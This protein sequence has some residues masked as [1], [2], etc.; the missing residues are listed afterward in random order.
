MAALR[1]HQHS[2][3]GERVALP[4]PPVAFWAAGEVGAIRALDHQP[5]NAGGARA[6][7]Q[8]GQLGLAFEGNQGR[9]VHARRAVGGVE[10]FQA[11]APFVE[12]QR[13]E[14]FV[15]VE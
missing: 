9:E 1:V 10:A 7:A 14:V 2:V 13:A 12:R 15:A 6:I 5:L 8:C 11:A 3:D 4:F